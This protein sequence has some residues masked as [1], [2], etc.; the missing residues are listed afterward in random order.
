MS[1]LSPLFLIG[2]LAGLIP[3]AIHFIR[4]EKPVKVPFSTLRFFENTSRKHFLFQRIQQWL[5]LLLRSAVV[6]LLALS[7]A[8]PF[9]NQNLSS[10]VDM[11]PQSQ[12][13]LIDTSSSMSY[14]GY[15]ERAKNEA[16]QKLDEL[17]P[18]DEVAIILFAETVNATRAFSSDVDSMKQFI[19]AIDEVQPQTTRYFPALRAAD[20]M[21][22]DGRFEEKSVVLI[23][24]FQQEGMVDFEPLWKLQPSVNFYPVD[25]AQADTRNL[26]ITGVKLPAQIRGESGDQQ[27]NARLRSF[28]GVLQ[29]NTNLILNIDG[30]PVAQQSVSLAGQSER[31]VSLPLKLEAAGSHSGSIKIEGDRFTADD[32]F[33]FTIDVLPKI[34]VLVING[35]SSSNW[36]D[37]E[38]HWFELA[39]QGDELSPF[40]VNSVQAEQ[41]RPNATITNDV[42]VLLNVPQLNDSQAQALQSYVEGGGK[43]L[44]APGDRVEAR[45]FNRQLGV[46]SPATLIAVNQTRRD[47]YL[48]I[49]D[50]SFRHPILQ[51]LDLDWNVR[52]EGN[53]QVQPHESAEVIMSFDNGMP[54]LLEREVENGRVLLFSSAL[55]LEWNNLPLQGIYLPFVHQ[56]LKYL[57]QTEQKQSSY[58][59]GEFVAINNHLTALRSPQGETLPLTEEANSFVLDKP[60]VYQATIKDLPVYYAANISRAESAF[61]RVSPG[62]LLDQVLNP[63]TKPSQSRDVRIQLLSQEIEKPQRLWWWLL[64]L[65][66][67]LVVT[68]SFVANRTHR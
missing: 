51:P 47:D 2:L 30:K 6:A 46:V 8:R 25:I 14:P 65:V 12:V 9:F 59:V 29:E 53:W 55:D 68:E 22:K 58:T 44:I 52:F 13:L 18:G 61:A 57:A 60:G 64:L 50:M 63:E 24:D 16:R 43:L 11:A 37:D 36:Y 3:I 10:L 5:L 28:G 54:A 41:W 39:A 40:A 38:G 20:E 49:A 17:G 35:E 67:L 45:E 4:R 62:D 27:L 15:L 48:V 26:A 19:T 33:Y 66:T 1:F 31:V 34:D 32:E 7:F 21:L 23:S 42:I 56:M